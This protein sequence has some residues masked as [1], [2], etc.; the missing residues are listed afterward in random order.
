MSSATFISVLI[1]GLARS[2]SLFLVSAGLTLIFGVTRIINFAHGSFYMLGAYFAYSLMQVLPNTLANF[3]L[4]AIGT[5]ILIGGLGAI[6]ELALF[7][8]LY[9]VD[10]LLQLLAT[11]GVVL[12]LQDVT[13]WIWGPE[14]LVSSRIPTLSNAIHIGEARIA[15]YNFF[16]IAVGITALL[17]LLFFLKRTRLGILIRAATHDREMVAA[18]GVNQKWLFTLVLFLGTMFAGLGGAL[19]LPREAASLEMD[20]S[21]IIEAFAV[22]VIGGMGSPMGAFLAALIVGIGQSIGVLFFPKMTLVM[23]FLIMAFVLIVRP[24]GLTGDPQM[25]NA[26]I[27]RNFPLLEMPTA[28]YRYLEWL[29]VAGLVIAPLVLG[30]YAVSFLIDVLIAVMLAVSLHLILGPGGMHSFGHAAYFGLGAY[31]VGLLTTKVGLHFG[32]A[33]F[34][35]P[36]VA[37]LGALVFGWLC[38]RAYGVY[39]SMLTLALAQIVYSI[40]FQWYPVTGG[41]N[42]LLGA[43]PTGILGDKHYFFYLVLA[44]CVLAVVMFRRILFSSFGFCLRAGRDA[45][46]RAEAIGIDTNQMRLY[47]F[48]VAG[49]LAG[50]AGGLQTLTKGS[51][52][53]DALSI[54]T[55]VDGLIMV[56]IGGLESVVGP[57]IGGFLFSLVEKS[58]ISATELWRSVLGVIIVTIILVLPSGLVGLRDRLMTRAGRIRLR[59]SSRHER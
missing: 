10:S 52:F 55:S 8:R 6:L 43:W 3:L 39:F 11:F 56:L 41:D 18:L 17:A 23:A 1:D 29:V 30:N 48:C 33:L 4:I 31:A 16:M 25:N 57:V 32:L 35:A 27:V 37:A 12:I 9:S 51:V 15:A 28:G 40:A 2:A 50:V 49:A 13:K 47:A 45:T 26:P 38:I 44:V 21:I 36:F 19:Q 54:A 42:G 53:P 34:A 5:T 20:L 58:L 24:S 46:D 7:R 22:V 14:I 59:A